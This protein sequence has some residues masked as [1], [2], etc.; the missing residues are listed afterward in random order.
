MYIERHI[1][2][3][4]WELLMKEFN[5]KDEKWFKDIF[6]NKEA[7]V[8]VYFNDFPRYGLM[9]TTSRSESINSFFNTYSETG[10]FFLNFMMNYDAAI[11]K[12]RYTYREL[13]HKTKGA[14]YSWRSPRMIEQIAAKGYTSKVFFFE[15]QKE[16]YKGGWFCEVIDFGEG[17]GWEIFKVIHKNQK[18][19][20]KATYKVELKYDEKEVSCTCRHFNR[21]G[22]L[23]RHAF[24][25]SRDRFDEE[26]EEVTKLVNEVFLNVKTALDIVRHDKQKLAFLAEKTEI[27]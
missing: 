22:I 20:V 9:K 7:W 4:S 1:F 13:D 27:L 3:R 23:C 21:F 25:L 26:D 6:E 18:H 19:E 11:K 8:P 12:Q 2:K 16:I 14:K 24:R 10:N 15:V 17:D 5:L